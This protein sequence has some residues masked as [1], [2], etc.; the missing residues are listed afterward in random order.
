MDRDDQQMVNWYHDIIKC[1]AENHLMVDFHGAYKPEDVYKRQDLYGLSENNKL[2]IFN[3]KVSSFAEKDR[4]GIR[5]SKK[6]ND[7]MAWLAN[8]V[9]SNGIIE[10]DI[11]GKD[12]YQQS[13]VGIAFHGVDNNTLDAA[14]FRPFN[15]QSTDV[16]KRQVIDFP[17]DC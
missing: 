13:F 6:E 15:F 4:K 1:A 9:F 16:Y 17:R 10:L 14:Y 11:R 7:G 5:F 2:E 12:E 3:R 8:V